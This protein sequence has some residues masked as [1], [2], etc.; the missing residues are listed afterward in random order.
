MNNIVKSLRWENNEDQSNDVSNKQTA[1][2]G[3]L[4]LEYRLCLMDDEWLWYV[5]SKNEAKGFSPFSCNTTEQEAKESCQKHYEDLVLS[6]LSTEATGLLL[7][8]DF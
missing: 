6:M 1:Q 2:M 3:I 8:H 4:G 5:Y 7:K